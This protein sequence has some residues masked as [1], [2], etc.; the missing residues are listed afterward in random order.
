ME[1]LKLIALDADDLSVVSAHLQDAV[2]RVGDIAYLPQ[3]KRFAAILNRFDWARAA[4]NQPRRRA[5]NERRRAGL[6]FERV[7]GAKLQ[8]I[9][10]KAKD[11]VLSLL[12]IQYEQ[13]VPDDPAGLVTLIFAGNAA[14]RL[15][16]ECIEAEMKDLGGAWRARSKPDHPGGGDNPASGT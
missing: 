1:I 12:A 9:D 2:V 6:R 7:R 4:A 11:A 13:L 14:I 5:H 16:V 3:Y 10:L 15:D 8:G